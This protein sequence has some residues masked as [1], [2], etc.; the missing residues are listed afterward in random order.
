M[1]GEIGG[2]G[3]ERA[4]EFI[5]SSMTS[6]SSRTSRRDGTRGPEDGHAGAIISGSKGTA[7][8]KMEALSAAGVLVAKNPRKPASSWSSSCGP[9]KGR[10]SD[11][12]ARPGEISLE[13]INAARPAVDRIAVRTRFSVRAF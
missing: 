6:P 2:D 10:R 4:A 13:A 7:K 12:G 11:R 8:A 5:A 3:E 1:I 9:C